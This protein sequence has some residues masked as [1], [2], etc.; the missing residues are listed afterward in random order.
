M[1]DQPSKL[2]PWVLVLILLCVLAFFG[3]LWAL[4]SATA[5]T[6]EEVTTPISAKVDAVAN[7]VDTSITNLKRIA[8]MVEFIYQHEQKEGQVPAAAVAP[9]AEGKA[10]AAAAPAVKPGEKA[11]AKPAEAA[12]PA[13]KAAKPAEAAKPA[14]KAAAPKK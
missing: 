6:I 10:P 11:A 12:K 7:S 8:D 13:A 14:A 5:S 9:E 1:N 3:G 2:E 4:G